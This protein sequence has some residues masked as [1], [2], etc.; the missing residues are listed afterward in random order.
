[1]SG[2]PDGRP[3]A[4]KSSLPEL[5]P[6]LSS[7]P[8]AIIN[9]RRAP[10]ETPVSERVIL[11]FV[12]PDYQWLCR[13]VQ[14]AQP[15]RYLWDCACREGLL[16]GKPVTVVAPAM[17][18]PYAVMVLERLIALGARM[19]LALGWCGSLQPEV[20]I[21][22][23]VLPTAAVSGEG[24][25]RYYPLAGG[26]AGDPAP[27]PALLALLREE[28]EGSEGVYHAGPMW[29]TDAIYRETSELVRNLQAQGLLAVD[30]E[31]AALFQVGQFRQ[32]PLAGL[33]VVSDEL[34]TLRWR[35]GHRSERFRQGRDL[36]ARLILGAAARWEPPHV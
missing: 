31:M 17:G 24:T 26:E 32:V 10:G 35:H 5:A 12:Q 22:S 8:E 1:M 4:G 15:V 27:D 29:T 33:L 28:L 11:T 34:A 36:A 2:N 23:L 25:S 6:H 21:G 7:N 13:L 9:P 14:A 16:Q 19:V 30:L 3:R 20:A 18:A